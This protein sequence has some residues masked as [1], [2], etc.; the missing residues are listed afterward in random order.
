MRNDELVIETLHLEIQRLKQELFEVSRFSVAVAERLTVNPYSPRLAP[1]PLDL[2]AVQQKN[3]IAH[4]GDIDLYRYI[5]AVMNGTVYPTTRTV[6]NDLTQHP[7]YL[8]DFANGG[9]VTSRAEVPQ[10]NSLTVWPDGTVGEHPSFPHGQTVN[11]P[12]GDVNVAGTP[13]LHINH[14]WG[15]N[16]SYIETLSLEQRTVSVSVKQ[17]LPYLD[18]ALLQSLLADQFFPDAPAKLRDA[19]ESV[20]NTLLELEKIVVSDRTTCSVHNGFVLVHEAHPE[21]Y[22]L[23]ITGVKAPTGLSFAFEVESVREFLTQWDA[24]PLRTR[25]DFYAA[26]QTVWLTYKHY[27]RL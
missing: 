14:A 9:I 11:L 4:G 2:A 18:P 19:M 16:V 27:K 6:C 13:T 10:S 21:H 22:R 25:M 20:L 1:A 3:S 7:D 26:C 8:F 23:E 17:F 15:S 24:L 5:K 12:L